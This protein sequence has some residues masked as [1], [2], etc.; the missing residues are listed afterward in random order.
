MINAERKV[1]LIDFGLLVALPEGKSDYQGSQAGTIGYFAP[2]S[3]PLSGKSKFSALTDVWQAGVVLYVLLSGSLPFNIS[4]VNIRKGKYAPLSGSQWEKRSEEC[5]DLVKRMLVVNPLQRITCAEILT[6]AWLAPSAPKEVFDREYYQRIASLAVRRN[7]KRMLEDMR[8]GAEEDGQ[9]DRKARASSIMRRVRLTSEM[10]YFQLRTGALKCWLLQRLTGDYTYH[11]AIS[12]VEF[13]SMMGEH[14]LPEMQNEVIYRRFVDDEL[15]S[16]EECRVTVKELL[17]TLIALC[18]ME[19]DSDDAFITFLK[20]DLN[21][22]GF[23]S[24]DEMEL[25]FRSILEE[26]ALECMVAAE[27]PPDEDGETKGLVDIESEMVAIEEVLRAISVKNEKG[28]DFSEFKNFFDMAMKIS[29]NMS[30]RLS[31]NMSVRV[32]MKFMHAAKSARIAV[33]TRPKPETR[34]QL[35]A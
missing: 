30:M 21:K 7:I 12:Y 19:D 22:D 23:I 11:S 29:N 34:K 25:L 8:E 6:H 5:K 31:M 10:M 26:E 16:L 14:Q 28:I 27:G 20:F 15:T 4:S 18:Q 13:V 9:F 1:K 24:K 2:E 33:A 35:S 32:S 17:L 3:I